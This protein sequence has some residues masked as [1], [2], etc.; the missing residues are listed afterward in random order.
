MSVGGVFDTLLPLVHAGLVPDFLLRAGIRSLLGARASAQDALSL[1]ARVAAKAAYVADLKTRGL[2]EQTGAANEQHYEVPADFYAFVMGAHRKYSC[3]LWPADG[4]P[5]T[6][7]ESEAAALALVCERAGLSAATPAGARV[8][9]MGCGW[10]SF[11]LF[12][13][14]RFPQLR[15]TGVSNSASQRAYILGQAAERGI[16]NLEIV[17]ADINVFDGAGRNFDFVVSI[18]MMEHGAW[19][20]AAARACIANH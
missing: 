7:D 1:P 17:T 2:A 15:V 8:L 18:E 16:T 4:A 12:A 6:L 14:G 3:G 10:G 11:S 19:R 13:A 9:D 5:A 20:G